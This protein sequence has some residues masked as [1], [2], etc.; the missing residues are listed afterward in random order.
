MS[1]LRCQVVY[2]ETEGE[3]DL[4]VLN[5]KWL[6][7]DIIGHL[8]SH[9]QLETSRPTGCFSIDDFQLMCPETDAK[10]LLGVLEALNMCT[11]CPIDGDVE[12]EFPCLNF[13]ET[14]HGLWERD[15]SRL[16]NPVY[17]GVRIQCAR[18]INNQLLHMFPRIQVSLRHYV[19]EEHAGMDVDLYQWYHGS[20]LCNNNMECLISLEQSE[21]AIEVKCRGSVDSQTSLYYFQ[22][23]LLS[24]V[25]DVFEDSCPGVALEKNILSSSHLKAHRK[26]PHA[27]TGKDILS[28]QLD[29]CSCVT[30]D[31]GTTEELV[32]L[33]AFGSDEI[34]N[35][36][37]PGAELHVSYLSLPVRQSISALL[38]PPDSLGKDW[39]LLAV[40]LGMTEDLPKV[41]G[42]GSQQLR[43][44]TDSIIQMWSRDPAATV[45]GLAGRLA[46]LGR[47]DAVDALL[48]G[49]PLYQIAPSEDDTPPTN[50]LPGQADTRSSDNTLSSTLSR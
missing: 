3:D 21:Q 30:L 43:S 8:L 39:C 11:R 6:C 20:K 42:D 9:D 24:V 23:D 50:T 46:D 19:L 2:I 38:D 22:E 17:G 4:V 29:G 16:A 14:L 31:S 26:N 48:S 35:N 49:C 7:S 47:Q 33:V 37:T 40:K 18:G 10:D 15:D 27:Y 5:P 1:P 13:V 45:A 25:L 28:A 32:D 36:M 12:Y 34:W 44:K 41:D